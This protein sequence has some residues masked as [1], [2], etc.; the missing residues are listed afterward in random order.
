MAAGAEIS[1][2]VA[3]AA[4]AK[5]T[6]L[7]SESESSKSESESEFNVQKLVDMFTKL[8]PLAKEFIPSSYA[9]QQSFNN[10]NAITTDE[11]LFPNNKLFPDDNNSINRRRRNNFNQGRRRL[12]G[13]SF[14]AQRDNSIRRTVYVSDIDQL[15]TEERLAALFSTCGQY[16]WEAPQLSKDNAFLLDA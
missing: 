12:N 11:S 10:L 6:K 15:V 5:N 9:K 3:A 8:N 7:E 14:R 16:Y 2:E 13:R 1:G 4:A